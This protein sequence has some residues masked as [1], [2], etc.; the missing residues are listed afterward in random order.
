MSRFYKTSG[1]NPIDWAYQLP[2]QEMLQ[3]LM[4][5]Q[6]AQDRMIAATGQIESL[7]QKLRFLNA[8]RTEAMRQMEWLDSNVQQ[9]TGMDLTDPTNRAKL[10]GFAREAARRWG[11]SGIAGKISSNFASFQAYQDA[12]SK[13]SNISQFRRRRA[14]EKSL[15]DYKGVGSSDPY[16]GEYKSFSGFTPT[17]DFA[18]QD[19]WL[20]IASKVKGDK[21]TKKWAESNG[22]YIDN[23]EEMKTMNTEQKMAAMFQA[24]QNRPDVRNAIQEDVYLGVMEKDSVPQFLTQLYQSGMSTQALDS[25]TG[26]S[27]RADSWKIAQWKRKQEQA[28][29]YDPYTLSQ[30][31]AA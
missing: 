9:F 3:G 15:K 27:R 4:S 7:G 1:S 26:F 5:K 18:Y 12:L 21:I 25:E 2:Y 17:K 11:P 6:G 20:K 29:I 16:G 31:D 8:D 24:F 13:D 10:R 22:M 14:I 30:V 28:N 19:E 23:W